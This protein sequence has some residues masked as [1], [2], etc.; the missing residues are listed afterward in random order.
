M[1]RSRW[2]TILLVVSVGLNIAAVGFIAG[3]ATGDRFR[4]PFAN[5]LLGSGGLIRDL[6]EPRREQLS[7]IMREHGRDLHSSIREMRRAQDAL[8]EALA[9]P[10]FDRDETAAALDA[11]RDSLCSS[12]TRGNETIIAL[13]QAMT[14]EERMQLVERME[15]HGPGKMR[16]PPPPDEPGGWAD[17]PRSR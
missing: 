16:R 2:L 11:F 9:A 3:R 5:P 13:A 10:E 12:M 1:S 4:P 14:P 15:R 8:R 17:G 7:R 6:P